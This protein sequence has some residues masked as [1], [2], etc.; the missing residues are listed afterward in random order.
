MPDGAVVAAEADVETGGAKIGHAGNIFRVAD[1]VA[2]CD[3]GGG[4]EFARRLTISTA[5]QIFLTERQKRR[6]AD[7]A[8]D[9][10][11]VLGRARGKAVP[12]RAP[13]VEFVT[14]ST[15]SESARH[16]AH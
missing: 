11:Q 14:R 13:D 12:Q 7:A 6:L 2:E 4:P 5:A 3:A 10:D 15:S 1:A 16:L 9:H 8:G